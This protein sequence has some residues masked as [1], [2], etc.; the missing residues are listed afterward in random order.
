MNLGRCPLSIFCS[1]TNPES[2]IS[3]FWEGYRESR[4]CSRDTYPEPYITKSY[5]TNSRS[6]ISPILV[7]EE[8]THRFAEA[9]R[10]VVCAQQSKSTL[11]S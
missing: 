8:K 1:P 11:S 5:I 10:A 2:I 6:H 4:R 9:M 3:V 7:W